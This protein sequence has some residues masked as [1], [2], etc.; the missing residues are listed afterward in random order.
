MQ[1]STFSLWEN[2]KKKYK[3]LVISYF[4]TCVK[5]RP[6]YYLHKELYFSAQ[7]ELPVARRSGEGAVCRHGWAARGP[8]V[9]RGSS[10]AHGRDRPALR[11]KERTAAPAGTALNSVFSWEWVTR[12]VGGSGCASAAAASGAAPGDN[13]QETSGTTA[14]KLQRSHPEQVPGA[15][16]KGH[17]AT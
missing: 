4:S 2:K 7:W 5:H 12:D 6:K 15:L 3:C 14:R 9:L 17:R 13:C 16:A 11:L 8:P 1:C 10:S